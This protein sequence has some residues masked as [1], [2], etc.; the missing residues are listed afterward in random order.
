MACLPKVKR[1]FPS[2]PPPR[3][4]WVS[5]YLPCILRLYLEVFAVRRRVRG[6]LDASRVDI[7][8]GHVTYLA[9]R[10][11]LLQMSLAL[12][13]KKKLVSTICNRPL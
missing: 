13:A 12:K 6:P 10:W 11:K 2:S 1:G 4:W 7:D 9:S 8:R 5:D 3:H